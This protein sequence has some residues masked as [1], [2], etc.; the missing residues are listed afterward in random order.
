MKK[1]FCIISFIY[2]IAFFKMKNNILKI[3]CIKMIVFQCIT[4]K[5]IL[6]KRGKTSKHYIMTSTNN[7]LSTGSIGNY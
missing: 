1:I 3:S 2:F 4:N 7:N 5:L 6:Y